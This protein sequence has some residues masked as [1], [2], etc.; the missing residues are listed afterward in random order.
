MRQAVFLVVAAFVVGGGVPAEAQQEEP[1][2]Y[3]V[4]KRSTGIWAHIEMDTYCSQ[5]NPGQEPPWCGGNPVV[6]G[7]G[8]QNYAGRPDCQGTD[9]VTV[10]CRCL[11]ST[12]LKV[13]D[14]ESGTFHCRSKP[15]TEP[16]PKWDHAFSYDPGKW[17]CETRPFDAD[18]TDAAKRVKNCI[19]GVVGRNWNRISSVVRYASL[20]SGKL[21]RVN[22]CSMVGGVPSV[23]A[24]ELDRNQ[25]VGFAN[26]RGDSPWQW[27]ID[28]V[29]HESIHVDDMFRHNVCDVLLDDD[30]IG[31]LEDGGYY[32]ANDLETA[33][34][35]YVQ[36]RTNAE[37]FSNLGVRGPDD[38]NYVRARDGTLSCP[39][40]L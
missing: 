8:D 18:A 28:V 40:E 30:F 31:E 7:P 3:V 39:L 14:A 34:E 12:P 32:P 19:G 23:L 15:P 35:L 17:K 20:P 5:F 11:G 21:G 9:G 13:Y 2:I 37:Y 22:G 6:G 26:G 25:I 27:M 38:A 1:P 36:A 33:D 16:C 24:V 29:T 4:E 10:D